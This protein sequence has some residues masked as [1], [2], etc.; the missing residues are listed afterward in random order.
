MSWWEME[1][2]QIVRIHGVKLNSYPRN[3][4]SK[5]GDT[6]NYLSSTPVQKPTKNI[7]GNQCTMIRQKSKLQTNEKAE[8]PARKEGSFLGRD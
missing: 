1:S 2:P 4:T 7:F 6:E 5:F 3:S 8:R